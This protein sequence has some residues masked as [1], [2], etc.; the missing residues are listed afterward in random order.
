[1]AQKKI[2]IPGTDNVAPRRFQKQLD[3]EKQKLQ[4][5][6]SKEAMRLLEERKNV[7][8]KIHQLDPKTDLPEILE[9]EQKA[10][11]ILDKIDQPISLHDAYALALVK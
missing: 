8:R 11:D 7:L 3:K 10:Q 2:V 4:G 9:L 5:G 1:M 6:N